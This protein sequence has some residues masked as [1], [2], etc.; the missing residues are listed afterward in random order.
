MEEQ[1]TEQS[2]I[3]QFLAKLQRLVV[4]EDRGALA[5]LR[6]GFSPGTC[7]ICKMTPNAISG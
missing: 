6:H 5:D 4:Q 2:T 1:T 7:A 3:Q